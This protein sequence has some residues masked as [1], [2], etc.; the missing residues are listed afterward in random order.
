MTFSSVQSL[1]SV[2]SD[3]LWP[4]EPQ[5][6]RLP[7]SSPTPKV[8]PNSLVPFLGE[9]RNWIKFLECCWARHISYITSSKSH[10]N[11]IDEEWKVQKMGD[12]SPMVTQPR[13]CMSSIINHSLIQT[14]AQLLQENLSRNLFISFSSFV[15]QIKRKQKQSTLRVALVIHLTWKEIYLEENYT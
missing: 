8:Y 11:V 6:T 4:H 10:H 1:S 14:L 12:L 13:T 15:N 3:S 5:H 2:Q 7:C 9:V